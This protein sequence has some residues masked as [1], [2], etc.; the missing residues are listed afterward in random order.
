[1]RQTRAAANVCAEP[2]RH[3]GRRPQV[4]APIGDAEIPQM[5]GGAVCGVIDDDRFPVDPYEQS[6][7]APD[8]RTEFV[9]LVECRND[10]RKLRSCRRRRSRGLSP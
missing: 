1:M 2:L 10:D 5:F 8:Q 3:D 9:A 7:E 4:H 6:I